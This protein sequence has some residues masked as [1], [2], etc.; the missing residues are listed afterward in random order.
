MIAQPAG[1]AKVLPTAWKLLRLR[2]RISWN[3]FH[4]SRTI[5]KIVTIL[6]LLALAALAGIVFWLSWKMVSVLHMPELVQY[7]G[8]INKFINTIPVLIFTV[9]FLGILLTS[10]GVLLQALYLSGDMDFL[11]AAPVPIRAVFIAKLLQAILPNLGLSALLGLP[12]LY[13]FGAAGGYTAWYF[14]LAPLM[15]A[16]LSLS[17]AG[18]AGLLVMLV[19][20]VFPARRV[21]EVLGFLGAI[22]SIICSQTGNLMN[23]NNESANISSEQVNSA[24]G[25]LSRVDNPWIPLNWP[26]RGLVA[27]GTTHADYF[28]GEIPCTRKMTAQEIQGEYEK[29]T[30][31]VIKETFDGKDPDAIPAVL[32]YS[33]GPFAWGA[34]PMEAVHNA[35]VLEEIAFMNFHTLT[36]APGISP[37]QPD[38]LDKHF[39][40]KHGA[41]A[42]YG[43]NKKP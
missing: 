27:L 25:L 42:Y 6:G 16:A 21:A 10:F 33:H 43:Q 17:A 31:L 23:A 35:V 24:V 39:L 30:G 8:D 5:K 13:G 11:L 28:Y 32:V 40:R 26:G 15:M 3:S 12:V 20:R 29:E 36:L 14:L 18:V 9:F 4:R 34:D 38:L 1:T 41:N 2:W 37:M 19:V 7:V 22:F